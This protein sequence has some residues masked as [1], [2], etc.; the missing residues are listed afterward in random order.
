MVNRDYRDGLPLASALDL[1]LKILQGIDYLHEKGVVHGDIKPENLMI[2][3][4][5]REPETWV[6]LVTD[7][8]TVALIANP[9]EIEGKPAVVATP[10]YASVAELPF[11]SP[12]QAKKN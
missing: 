6:P 2:Q 7:F 1:F 8:G 5:P 10:R 11:P 4:N 12:R 3:G 9:V